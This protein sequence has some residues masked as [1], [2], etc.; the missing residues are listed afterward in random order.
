MEQFVDA[1]V[2]LLIL[3][4]AS[5]MCMPF[6]PEQFNQAQNLLVFILAKC[7]MTPFEFYCLVMYSKLIKT[8]SKL[9]C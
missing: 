1:D 8:P 3:S 7:P 6:S 2:T 5:D 9:C 4:T